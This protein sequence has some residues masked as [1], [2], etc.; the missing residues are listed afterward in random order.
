MNIVKVASVDGRIV[1]DISSDDEDK[2]AGFALLA[3]DVRSTLFGLMG[4]L[5]IIQ[6]DGLPVETLNALSRPRASSVQL[7]DLL[8]LVFG[9]TNLSEINIPLNVRAEIALFVQRWHDRAM[10]SEMQIEVEVLSSVETIDTIDRVSFHRILDNL[11]GNA[12]KYAQQG[13][14]TIKVLNVRDDIVFM[15]CDTGPGFCEKSLDNLFE[16][17]GRPDDSA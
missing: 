6:R 7:A 17:V 4:S 16:V 1:S 2:D 5:E 9:D 3:H 14:V 8:Q 15:V 10:Q 13:V 11:L 12:I